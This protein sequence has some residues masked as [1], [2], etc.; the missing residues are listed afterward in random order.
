MLNCYETPNTWPILKSGVLAAILLLC[1]GIQGVDA[2]DVVVEGTVIDAE[3][4][5]TLPG[6]NIVE[7]GTQRGTTTDVNGLFELEVTNENAT[8]RFSFVGYQAQTV[9]VEGRSELT[10]ELEPSPQQLEGVVV[11]ALGVERQQRSLGYATSQIEAQDL[12]DASESNPANLL[13]GNVP[14]LVVSPNSGGPNSSTS[15]RI[16]GV[17]AIGADNDPLFVVDGVPIDNTVFGSVGRFGGRDGGSALSIIN[18]DNIQNI[19]VLKGAGAA[20]LYGTR[21]RDGVVLVETKSG[22]GVSPDTYSVQYTSNLTSRNVLGSFADYQSQYGQGTRGRAPESADDA[23]SDGL[24]SWGRRY[25]EVNEAVQFDGQTRSYEEA[26]DRRG[27]YETGLSHKQSLAL[28]AGYE[29]ASLRLSGSYL[30][31]QSVVPNTGYEQGNVTLR[32]QSTF[33]NLSADGSVTYVTELYDNRVFLNDHPRNPNYLPSML[34]GNV[35]L[36]ALQPGF[37][38]EDG[39]VT[40][41]QVTDDVFFTNPYWATKRMSADDDKDR[42]LGNV[43]LNYQ[44]SDWISVQAQTG[45]DWYSLKRT[46]L[47]G[48]GTAFQPRG[49]LDEQEQRV[50]ESNTKLMATGTP[51]LTQNLSFRLDLG[52]SLQH[53]QSEG[54]TVL[55]DNMSI[56]YFRDLSNMR[57]RT[58]IYDFSE[59]QIRSFFGSAEFNYTDYLYLTLTGRSDWSSTLPEENVP[60]FYPSVSGSFVFSEAFSLPDW[61]SYGKVRASWAEIGGDTSPYQLD[62]TYSLLEQHQ[63]QTLGL[64]TQT[65]VPNFDLKP[66]S[67]T[68]TEIGLEAQF[69]DDRAGLDLTW[70]RRTTVDQILTATVSGASG[71]RNRIIN[72][73]EIQNSGVEVLLTTIPVSTDDW[74]WSSNLNFGANQNE[75]QSLAEGLDI[76]VDQANRGGT[77]NIAQIV[78]EPANVIYGTP[79]VYDDQGR[80][81]HD[82]NGQP[83]SGEP[84]VLGKGAPDWTSGFSNTVSYKNVSIN[85][86]VDAK[87]GGQVYS[88]TNADAYTNGLHK[89]TLDGRGQC[90]QQRGDSGYPEDCFVG[91]GVIG[92]VQDGE[93][94][95]DGENDVG[96]RPSEYYGQIGSS[97]AE[98]FIYDANF[99]K[100]RQ[101]RITYELPNSLITQTPLSRAQVSLVGRNLLYLYDSVPNVNPESSYNNDSAPGFERAGVP[102]TRSFGF[103]LS[104]QL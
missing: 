79:Y 7:V 36:D 34:P 64:V 77:A 89:N 22:R 2:Q 52:G 103:T 46:T 35:P 60:F 87:W 51:N 61:V 39:Q 11:T 3:T 33:G 85:T 82:E 99:V 40:E 23:R 72:S 69:F 4:G 55:G 13:Q 104:V 16:R 93:V 73:G 30:N 53:R 8:L 17:S 62:L 37:V 47:D 5:E 1:M 70:Y 19:S 100:L 65:S 91:E 18:P 29:E 68:E 58:P 63:G 66:T 15:I 96:V 41:K 67:T 38:K 32:G 81:V 54:L 45:L 75:V 49:S 56:P 80:L 71:Y 102:E 98:E 9:A 76:R 28:N 6:V 90:D 88:G 48:F 95:V 26:L 24:S 74:S 84:E 25:E 43:N 27:F 59:Q 12:V 14:G 83:L 21:A 50:W 31:N 10:V 92:S 86:L 57:N 101:V 44:L 42:I 97:I 20:A 78:G 94:T